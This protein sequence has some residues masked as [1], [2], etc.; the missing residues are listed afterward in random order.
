[1]TKMN[2]KK[3]TCKSVLPLDSFSSGKSICKACRAARYK[4][5]YEKKK[6]NS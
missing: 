5:K 4:E 6:A 3:S 1:M 2:S